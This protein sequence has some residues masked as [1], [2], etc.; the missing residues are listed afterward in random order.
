VTIGASQVGWIGYTAG[1][2]FMVIK[3]FSKNRGVSAAEG[4]Q[5]AGVS[6]EICGGGESGQQLQE[7]IQVV[8]ASSP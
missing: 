7:D 2:K 8:V 4:K 1:I 5:A 6:M 3:W